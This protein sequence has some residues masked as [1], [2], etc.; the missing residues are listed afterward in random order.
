VVVAV[1]AL[2]VVHPNL[3]VAVDRVHSNATSRVTRRDAPQT[4]RPIARLKPLG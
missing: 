1:P 2:G 4:Q 3:A